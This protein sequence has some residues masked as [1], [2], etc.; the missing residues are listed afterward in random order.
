MLGRIATFANSTSLMTS[1]LDLQSRLA[2]AQ[3]QQA[4]GLVSTTYGG[5]GGDTG[6]LLGLQSRV[7][8]AQ[9]ESD[10]AGEA[11]AL[12]EQAWSALGD[13][14]D[15]AS[16][17]RSEVSARISGA[18]DLDGVASLA[19]DW[20]GELGDI[21][22]GRYGDRSLFGGQ[23]TDSAA[24]DVSSLDLSAAFETSD[25]YQGSDKALSL[26]LSSGR[27]VSLS[28]SANDPGIVALVDGLAA[29]ATATTTADLST[30]YDKLTAG[31]E[32]LATHQETLAV[33]TGVLTDHQ[34]R[35]QTSAETLE[36]LAKTLSGKD[37]AEATVEVTNLQTQLQ[38]LYSSISALSKVRLLDY[39]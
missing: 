33:R 22:N 4:S 20:L 1:A 32:A 34:T 13:L 12:M 21:L 9:A 19:Q 7:T 24:V 31:I 23:A 25:W 39:L 3:A 10:A 15:L 29:L 8:R 27:S 2:T 16:G 36:A 26:D 35:M 37:L 11:A 6:M 14:S 5:L 18:A 28:I 30:A 38:T 17:I